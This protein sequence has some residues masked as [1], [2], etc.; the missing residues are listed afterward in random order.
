MVDHFGLVEPNDRLGK[1]VVLGIAD[2]AR[3]WLDADLGQALRVPNKEVSGKFN[4]S[5]QHL[6]EGAC[7]ENQEAA[8]R[9]CGTC[10]DALTRPAP[11]CISCGETAFW[12]AIAKGWSSE[13]A[14]ASAQVSQAVKARWFREAGGMPPSHLSSSAPPLSGRYLSFAEREQ[15]ALLRAKDLGVREISRQLERAATTFSRRS[16]RQTLRAPYARKLAL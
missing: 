15:I 5:S 2:G 3:R 4:R 16:C 7:D 10:Q 14:A 11:G 9:S 12:R 1:R 6:K 8:V 13:E